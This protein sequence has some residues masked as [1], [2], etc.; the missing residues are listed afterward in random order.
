MS[1]ERDD[2]ELMRSAALRNAT[3]VMA[4]RQRAEAEPHGERGYG[5]ADEEAADVAGAQGQRERLMKGD[6]RHVGCAQQR[7]GKKD[8]SQRTIG[9]RRGRLALSVPRGH[10]RQ[11]QPEA[12]AQQRSGG[13]RD[14]HPAPAVVLGD[15][16]GSGIY[17]LVGIMAAEVGGAFWTSF[18]VGITVAL[19]GRATFGISPAAVMSVMKS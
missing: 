18:L 17:A 13:R 15:V 11:G 10:R 9:R 1:E 19:L 4:D 14:E 7:R 6:R 3:K 12:E 5:E 8:R 16:L 2:L